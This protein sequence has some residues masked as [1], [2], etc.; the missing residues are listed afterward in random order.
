MIISVFTSLSFGQSFTISELININ[1]YQ[2]DDFDTY[3]T[4]KGYQYYKNNN[5]D[6]AE[7]TS[8]VYYI[9]GKKKAY[10]TKYKYKQYNKKMVSFQTD[11]N[12]TYLKIK[13]ELKTIGFKFINSESY[14]GTTFFNYKKGN[15]EVSLASSV[16]VSNYG[17]NL[18]N[19]EISISK[20][21]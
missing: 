2:L 17:R 15:I 10:I 3:I 1:N 16:Q 8:Y 11:N 14:K 9:N 19:Y 13:S 5:T 20:I 21:Y 7:S 18:N 4:Q 6:F 12:S